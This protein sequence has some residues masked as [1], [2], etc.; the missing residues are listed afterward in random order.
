MHGYKMNSKFRCV[1]SQQWGVRQLYFF[2]RDSAFVSI[3]DW[4]EGNKNKIT[5]IF[6]FREEGFL[7]GAEYKVLQKKLQLMG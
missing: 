1:E 6:I 2:M 7:K 3:C 5:C 4:V